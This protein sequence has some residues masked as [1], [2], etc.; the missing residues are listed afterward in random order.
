M[1]KNSSNEKQIVQMKKLQKNCLYESIFTLLVLYLINFI[2]QYIP[3]L[4]H[5]LQILIIFSFLQSQIALLFYLITIFF[6]NIDY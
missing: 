4:F 5:D 6:N 2:Q 1:K 3:F